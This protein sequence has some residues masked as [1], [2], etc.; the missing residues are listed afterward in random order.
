MWASATKRERGIL[1]E[2]AIEAIDRL[3]LLALLVGEEAVDVERQVV[4]AEPR[5]VLEDAR[6]EIARGLEIRVGRGPRWSTGFASQ[7]LEA[8]DELLALELPLQLAEAEQRLGHLARLARRLGDERGEQA[9]GLAAERLDLRD[10][11]LD[12]RLELLLELLAERV[13]ELRAVGGGP[14]ARTVQSRGAVPLRSPRLA[15]GLTTGFATMA[16][17]AAARTLDVAG[18]LAPGARIGGLALVVRRGLRMR[19]RRRGAPRPRPH[20]SSSKSESERGSPR[21]SMIHHDLEESHASVVIVEAAPGLRDEHPVPVDVY[22]PVVGRSPAPGPAPRSETGRGSRCLRGATRPLRSRRGSPWPSRCS[23][24][25]SATVAEEIFTSVCPGRGRHHEAATVPFAGVDAVEVHRSLRVEDR[26]VVGQR[27]TELLR[28]GGRVDARL[29]ELGD[30]RLRAGGRTREG[31]R[32]RGG[33]RRGRRRCGR[34]GRRR[35]RGRDDAAETDGAA[36]TAAAALVDV[37]VAVAVAHRLDLGRRL[38]AGGDGEERQRRPRDRHLHFKP[39]LPT[40]SSG[41]SSPSNGQ[42]S[43][44]SRR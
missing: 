29:H 33:R 6:E 30:E 1:L 4:L 24:S 16:V 20:S 32:G 8:L 12:A 3:V 13:G 26:L 9:D 40:N 44:L 28:E 15:P 14:A 43:S 5:I 7:A 11:A 19:R 42:Y 18:A 34:R 36:V 22:E 38:R 37:A 31:R 23:P 41:Q 27:G 10:V 35:G 2:D 39:S 17:S 25:R 21:P